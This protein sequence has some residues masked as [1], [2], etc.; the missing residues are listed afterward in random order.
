MR[1]KLWN[2]PSTSE[3]GIQQHKTTADWFPVH[4]GCMSQ[5][6]NTSD[7]R[8]KVACLK[9]AEAHRSNHK[10]EAS[11]VLFSPESPVQKKRAVCWLRALPV[12]LAHSGLK[13]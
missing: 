4:L 13:G 8:W 3:T 2:F 6:R 10:L 11:P 9:Q 1:K 12:P 7:T 5:A